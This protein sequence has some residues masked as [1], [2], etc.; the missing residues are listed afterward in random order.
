MAIKCVTYRIRNRAPSF[1]IHTI[2]ASRLQELLFQLSLFLYISDSVVL[3]FD[4]R[5]Q[6]FL[7][8]RLHGGP[9]GGA[10]TVV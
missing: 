7:G 3:V 10:D 9:V 5:T 1:P 8:Q 6:V 2:E 4:G